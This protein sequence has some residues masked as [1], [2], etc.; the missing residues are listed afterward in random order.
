[1]GFNVKRET[2]G[3]ERQRSDHCFAALFANYE[4]NPTIL[5]V[6]RMT[7]NQCG[8]DGQVVDL[9]QRDGRGSVNDPG[10]GSKGVQRQPPVVRGTTSM[11]IGTDSSSPRWIRRTM[12]ISGG[13]LSHGC[14]ANNPGASSTPNHSSR[15]W[16]RESRYGLALSWSTFQGSSKSAICGHHAGPHSTALSFLCARGELHGAP[17]T[18]CAVYV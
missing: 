10:P 13:C 12:S 8:R 15:A 16:R 14:K 17:R 11:P 5:T 9:L 18:P 7:R 1:M 6:E 4:C 2:I 3:F